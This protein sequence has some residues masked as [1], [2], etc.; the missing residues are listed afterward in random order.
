MISRTRKTVIGGLLLVVSQICAAQQVASEARVQEIAQRGAHV[1]PFNLERTQH[2]F[3]K[4][5]DGGL[6]QVV[7]KA[8]QDS[9][10][11]ALIRQHLSKIATEFAQGDFSDPE[12]IH[13]RDMPGLAAL[14]QAKVGQLKVEYRAM[15]RGAQIR[16]TSQEPTIIAALH[17]WFDA[18][19]SDH[20]RH[21]MP[22]HASHAGHHP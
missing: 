21:A 16:Y 17:Q 12:R 20:A 18:Q 6:Q 7:V 9:E 10:Q 19:L 14:R 5:N 8:P 13:G 1:M 4:L 15:E 11:V 2:Y 22:G 3:S